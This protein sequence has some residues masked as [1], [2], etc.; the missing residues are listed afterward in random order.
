M[1]LLVYPPRFDALRRRWVVWLAVLVAML[2]ALVPTVSHAVAWSQGSVA[3]WVE[4]CTDA[5][6]RWVGGNA[7]QAPLESPPGQEP[8]AA[9]AHCPF[10]LLAMERVLPATPTG[11]LLCV[12]QGGSAAPVAWQA[13]F[14]FTHVALRPPPR[15]PPEFLNY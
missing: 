9:A 1:S 14:F 4:V 11:P 15:G 10:C 5:G 3:P 7:S 12:E 6:M 2:G 13:V 8:T